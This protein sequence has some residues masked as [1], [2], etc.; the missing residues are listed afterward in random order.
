MNR[1]HVAVFP[2]D[3]GIAP[4][5]ELLF[6]VCPLGPSTYGNLTERSY[7]KVVPEQHTGVSPS[8]DWQRHAPQIGSPCSKAGDLA[9]SMIY[10]SAPV[11]KPVRFETNGFPKLNWTRRL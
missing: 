2:Q 5:S 3:V 4:K 10:G 1:F 7:E 11:A 9:S 8:T 6:A